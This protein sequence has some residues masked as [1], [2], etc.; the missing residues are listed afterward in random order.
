M[1]SDNLSLPD[2]PTPQTTPAGGGLFD[3][4]CCVLLET[5]RLGVSRKVATVEIVSRD[6]TADPEMIRVSKRILDSPEL[7]AIAKCHGEARRY[8]RSLVSSSVLTRGS[9]YTVA[10]DLIPRIDAR[11]QAY[12]DRADTLVAAFLS[13]YE[14]RKKEAL[15]KL[16]TVADETEYPDVARVAAAFG[17]HWQYFVFGAPGRL[18]EVKAEIWAREEEKARATWQSAIDDS[19]SMLA[20]G[21]RELIDHMIDRLTP[22]ADGRPKIFRDSLVSNLAEFLETFESRNLAGNAD[23]AAHVAT[24]RQ[25]LEGV[26]PDW[27]RKSRGAREALAARFADLKTALDATMIDAPRRKFG[28][29]DE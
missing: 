15:A 5:R 10:L 3:R 24:A 13:M 25:L 4:A 7:D 29:D 12:R 26:N 11:L 2:T 23:L 1:T 6:C 28:S 8:L 27:L 21:F 22:G 18:A 9:I 14:T 17:F 20:A 19:T 16:G